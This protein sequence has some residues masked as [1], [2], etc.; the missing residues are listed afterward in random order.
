MPAVFALYFHIAGA[1]L[2]DFMPAFGTGDPGVSLRGN[3]IHNA[4]KIML[5]VNSLL[6]ELKGSFSL[7]YETLSHLVL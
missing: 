4:P 7:R 5:D 6:S 3:F 1:D 2:C